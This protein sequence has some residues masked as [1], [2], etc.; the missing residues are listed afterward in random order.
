MLLF[1]HNLLVLL[2]HSIEFS[3][4]QTNPSLTSFMFTKPMPSPWAWVSPWGLRQVRLTWAIQVRIVL[5]DFPS[6]IKSNGKPVGPLEPFH[7]GNLYCSMC[8]LGG[9]QITLF[10]PRPTFWK[11]NPGTMA[12]L[13]MFTYKQNLATTHSQGTASHGEHIYQ[14][15]PPPAFINSAVQ[16]AHCLSSGCALSLCV[17]LPVTVCGCLCCRASMVWLHSQDG[18][19]AALNAPCCRPL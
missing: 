17:D 12:R 10:F 9:W 8:L 19:C 7:N 6:Q 1:G 3:L 2:H 14:S 13:H 4:Q 15:P 5:E 18:L 16:Y 11:Q